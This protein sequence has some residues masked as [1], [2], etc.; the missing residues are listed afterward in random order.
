MQP[1][2]FE[3]FCEEYTREMN[4][5]RMEQT[6]EERAEANE[7]ERVTRELDRCMDAI[8]EGVPPSRVKREDDGAAGVGT[9]ATTGASESQSSTCS[10]TSTPI[11]RRS[12]AARSPDL[13]EALNGDDAGV[14]RALGSVAIADRPGSP[15][16]HAGAA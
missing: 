11:W 9:R 16:P 8:A 4:R 6:A 1:D 2:L 7:L 5:L 3:E 15:H 10:R 13:L 14:Q 12:I